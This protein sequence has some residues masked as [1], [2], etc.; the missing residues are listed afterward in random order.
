MSLKRRLSTA[1]AE[2]FFPDSKKPR[3]RH[4][5]DH[6]SDLSDELLIRILQNL[7]IQSLIQCQRLSHRFY[8]LAGDS[9]IW[10]NLYYNRFVLPR[11]MRIP[12]IRAAPVDEALRFSS[13]TSKW[14]NDSYL[15]NRSDGKK[16][17]WKSQYKLRHNWAIGACEVQEINVADR[18]S[19]PATLAKLV[20]GIVVTANKEEG[21][22]AWDLKGKRVVAA[23]ELADGDIPTCLAVDTQNS[24]ENLLE[25]TVGFVD[26]GWGIWRLDV[27]TRSFNCAYRHPASSNGRLSAIAIANPYIITTTDSQLLSLYTLAGPPPASEPVSKGLSLQVEENITAEQDNGLEPESTEEQTQEL[28]DFKPHLLASLHSHTS[29]PPVTLSI[30]TTSTTIIASIAYS[31]PTYFEG[32]TI[33]LQELH[34]SPTTGTITSSRIATALPQGFHSSLKSSSMLAHSTFPEP[35]T[36]LTYAHPYL[37]A[38]H[39]DN[40]LTLYLC[41]STATHLGISTGGRLWGHTSSV[42][43]AEITPRGKAVSVSSR[44][45][46]LRV[47]DLEGGLATN[48]PPAPAPISHNSAERKPLDATAETGPSISR[49]STPYRPPR[50]KG[51]KSVMARS[52]AIRAELRS[53]PS[54]FSVASSDR[55]GGL[56]R[57][58]SDPALGRRSARGNDE[59]GNDYKLEQ[60]DM[61]EEE[62]SWVGFDDEVVIVLKESVGR[63]YPLRRGKQAL[64]VYDFR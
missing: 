11:A 6:L 17:N 31:L 12:G 3:T 55:P 14:L 16:T 64:V 62:S 7:P 19:V 30:R 27:T 57:V 32:Y 56:R 21:L 59:V 51:R 48:M 63:G 15:V 35:P 45:D 25:I 34:I 28:R 44:G 9:Q 37:L 53:S 41:T 33:G 54:K 22:R 43:A 10:K 40:T 5:L 4:P 52:V 18:P 38:C 29:W 46:E 36:S 50:A 1:Y 23:C 58:E 47:W 60:V 13:R 49:P 39:S 24:N 2:A 26:G 20:E 8:T 61:T 42:A